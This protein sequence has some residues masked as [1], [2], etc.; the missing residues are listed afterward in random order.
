MSPY[1]MRRLGF[2]GCK[3]TLVFEGYDLFPQPLHSNLH[4]MPITAGRG[5]CLHAPAQLWQHRGVEGDEPFRALAIGSHRQQLDAEREVGR[6]RPR[7]AKGNRFIEVK[8]PVRLFTAHQLQY[9]KMEC[10]ALLSHSTGSGQ[11]LISK[12]ID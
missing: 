4:D 11:A 8:S 1:T 5:A 2:T 9:F 12:E 10:R 6:R 3:K 7:Q